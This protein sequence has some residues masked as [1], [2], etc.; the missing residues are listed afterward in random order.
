AK[1]SPLLRLPRE[2]RDMI[3][4][5]A[6]GGHEV[7]PKHSPGYYSGKYRFGDETEQNWEN[8]FS[9]GL[10]CRQLNKETENMVYTL[11]IF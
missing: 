7:N 6:I 11:N 5:Y 8:M 2:V 9:L 3:Y 10:T 1:E 4:K